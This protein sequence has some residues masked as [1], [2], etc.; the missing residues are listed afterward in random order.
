M[1]EAELAALHDAAEDAEATGGRAV[2]AWLRLLA[3]GTEAEASGRK[4]ERG[5]ELD[6]T[7]PEMRRKRSVQHT[8][9]VGASG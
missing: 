4:R 3:R 5:L 6:S 9:P 1:A 7:P 8:Q 2:A